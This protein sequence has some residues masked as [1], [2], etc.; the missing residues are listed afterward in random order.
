MNLS[1]EQ[2][3][4]QTDFE[5]GEHDRRESNRVRFGEGGEPPDSL[6]ETTV[7][8]YGPYSFNDILALWA[9]EDEAFREIQRQEKEAFNLKY[10]YKL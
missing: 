5:R 9:G 10:G 4:K 1:N 2:R 8:I 7:T 3:Q 6:I